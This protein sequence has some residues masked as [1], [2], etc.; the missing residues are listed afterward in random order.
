MTVA[1]QI[2]RHH[3]WVFLVRGILALL[4]GIVALADPLIVLLA[5]IYV[6][7]VYAILDGITAIG[8]SLQERS[9][10]RAWWVILLEGIVGILYGGIP[11]FPV[12]RSHSLCTRSGYCAYEP[13][14]S[15]L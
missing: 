12:H 3:W 10:L 2:A 15:L 14:G 5:F 7:A 9:S 11:G 6:F 1:A 4:F 8:V 13:Y